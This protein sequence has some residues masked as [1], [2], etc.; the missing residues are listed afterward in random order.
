M[1]L[2]YE[3][4]FCPECKSIRYLKLGNVCVNCKDKIILE[5]ISQ[6]RKTHTILNEQLCFQ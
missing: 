4:F 1:K 6:S 2:I 3:K 5:N